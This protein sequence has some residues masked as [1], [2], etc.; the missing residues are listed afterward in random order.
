M[1]AGFTSASSSLFLT[2]IFGLA[3][4]VS[5]ITFMF[6]FMRILG[7]RSWLK[8]GSAICGVAMAI[9]AYY[10]KIMPAPDL[11]HDATLSVGGAISVLMVYVFAFFFG[12]S[13]GPIL[14][15]LC[16]EIFPSHVTAKCCAITT[17]TQWLFQIVI[18]AMT[19]Y[20]LAS[21]GWA[22]YLIYATFCAISLIWVSVCVPETRGVPLGRP[23]DALFD[24]S[25][26]DEVTAEEAEDVLETTALLRHQR[27]RSSIAIPV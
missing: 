21:V 12:A 25:L 14:W 23:M 5:A 18:A 17:C 11:T 8:L 3:K 9:L 10:V 4:L 6:V 2:G 1:T 19:P 15:N 27:R 24:N 20:L 7:N 22:T 26:K 13:L 16:S